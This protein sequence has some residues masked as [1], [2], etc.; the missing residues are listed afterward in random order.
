MKE[1][2]FSS[3]CISVAFKL[4]PKCEYTYLWSYHVG[5]EPNCLENFWPQVLSTPLL[6]QQSCP[7]S[8]IESIET[9]AHNIFY[10][11]F[12]RFLSIKLL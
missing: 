10:Q 8:L 7:Q 11:F 5:S 3:C 2:N 12:N 6:H 9:F 1:G 4:K